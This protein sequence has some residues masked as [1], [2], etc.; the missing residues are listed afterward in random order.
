MCMTKDIFALIGFMAII[1]AALLFGCLAFEAIRDSIRWYKRTYEYKHRFGKKPIAKC[2][3]HDC[4]WHNNE[5]G[6]CFRFFEE[7]GRLTGDT[8]FCYEAEPRES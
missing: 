1:G 4:K 8:A 7:N 6:R 2:Y 5:T 3:C